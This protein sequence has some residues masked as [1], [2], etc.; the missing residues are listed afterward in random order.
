MTK[1]MVQYHNKGKK[2]S[3]DNVQVII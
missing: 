3:G 2:K 1:E